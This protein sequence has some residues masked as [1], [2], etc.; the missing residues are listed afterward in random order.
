M[1]A[2]NIP[3]VFFIIAWLHRL[4]VCQWSVFVC[5]FFFFFFLAW[6]HQ[7]YKNNYLIPSPSLQKHF[8]NHFLFI[9]CHAPSL[10]SRG[11]PRN[12]HCLFFH[13]CFLGAA[14]FKVIVALNNLHAIFLLAF[15][16][17]TNQEHLAVSKDLHSLPCCTFLVFYNEQ[18]HQIDLMGLLQLLSYTFLGFSSAQE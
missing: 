16:S 4:K 1:I 7:I 13:L 10:H 15:A 18:E 5:I 17:Q 11:I 8:L 14:I 12:V 6:T 3:P 9:F 2:Y